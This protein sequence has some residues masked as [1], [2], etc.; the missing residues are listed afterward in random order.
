MSVQELWNRYLDWGPGRLSQEE[1]IRMRSDLTS[2]R[3]HLSQDAPGLPPHRW[4]SDWQQQANELETLLTRAVQN[5]EGL[6]FVTG[7]A[8]LIPNRALYDRCE[9]ALSRLHELNSELT[10]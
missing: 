2:C 6:C 10:P 4:R 5:P 1:L 9:S 3:D 7:E 8:G